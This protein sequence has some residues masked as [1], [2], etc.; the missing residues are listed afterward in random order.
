MIHNNSSSMDLDNSASEVVIENYNS[1]C[2]NQ[3]YLLLEDVYSTKITQSILE[4]NYLG[5]DKQIVLALLNSRVV[6]CAFLDY[7]TDYIRDRRTVF[8]SYV[9]VDSSVRQKGIGS[10]IFSEI[11]N[12]AKHRK[13]SAIELTSANYRTS[14]HAFYHALGFTKKQTTVFIKELSVNSENGADEI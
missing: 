7:N 10:K 4:R 13:C 14:A 1:S 6:G 11:E 9:A 12:R 3:L 5:Q 2:F 8:V